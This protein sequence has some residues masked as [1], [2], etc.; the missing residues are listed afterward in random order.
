ME[1]FHVPLVRSFA[2][3]KLDLTMFQYNCLYVLS[4]PYFVQA[5]MTSFLPYARSQCINSKQQQQLDEAT[6]QSKEKDRLHEAKNKKF[7]EQ[8]NLLEENGFLLENK[9]GEIA[10]IK[11]YLDV[12]ESGLDKRRR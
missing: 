3:R 4:R 9:D 7:E 5:L 8:A 12:V 11:L 6:S 2:L 10:K 1:L